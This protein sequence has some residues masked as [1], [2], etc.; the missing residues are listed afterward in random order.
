MLFRSNSPR[1]G[2]F[3][4]NK[5]KSLYI[6]WVNCSNKISAVCHP[7]A[8]LAAAMI[9]PVEWFRWPA[10]QPEPRDAGNVSVVDL[11]PNRARGH[12]H[13]NLL[14]PRNQRHGL[15]TKRQQHGPLDGLHATAATG[16]RTHG[17]AAPRDYESVPTQRAWSPRRT[18]KRM[19]SHSRA[20]LNSM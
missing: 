2:S 16:G 18:F 5:C 7:S 19:Y 3:S 1:I 6:F 4:E 17:K 20:S 10:T 14:N 8:V 9:P 15:L 13:G 12:V 11:V